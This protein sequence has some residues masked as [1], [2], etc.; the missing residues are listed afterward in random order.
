[1]EVQSAI[2]KN[3]L[4]RS[5]CTKD[6]TLT[7]NA[8]IKKSGKWLMYAGYLFVA[9]WGLLEL[10]Y[11]YQWIDFYTAE[12]RGLNPEQALR[13]R[14]GKTRILLLGDSFSAQPRSYVNTLRDSLPGADIINAAVPGT[15]IREAAIIGADK[16]GRF[17]PDVLI[18][19]VYVGNDLWDIRKSY[20]HAQ[21]SRARKLYWWL[22]DYSLFL[23]YL[24]YRAGQLK[25]GA[26]L[27][28][29]QRELK[30][31]I[32]FSAALYS[33]RERLL[34]QAEPGLIRQSILTQGERGKDLD[35]WFK[36]MDELISRLPPRTQKI[37]L[38]ILPHC[39]QVDDFYRKNLGLLGAE[40]SG[41]EIGQAKYPFLV[42][43]QQHYAGQPR[44]SVCSPLT[45][46]QQNDSTGHRLFYENDPHLNDAGHLLLGQYLYNQLKADTFRRALPEH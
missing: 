3:R 43:I 24:N 35:V 7:L 41:L 22:S 31:D 46:F 10:A 9:V 16:I 18:Y 11:R 14:A 30:Q 33:R 20:E 27:A 38:L 26:G 13:G 25:A 17:P 15:G 29:E 44:I 19:Q 6:T 8:F 28:V 42:R 12:L 39:V 32:A 2:S 5:I 4:F 23:R 34:L 36:K 21:I 1:M 40:P 45:V 37:V